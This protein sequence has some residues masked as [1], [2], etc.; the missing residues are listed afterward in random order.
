VRD[1]LEA[2]GL[3]AAALPF[4]WARP[5]GLA[6]EGEAIALRAEAL[7]GPGGRAAV[8]WCAG[9][10]GFSAT[11]EEARAE[12]AA[13]AEVL[14][15]ARRL[16]A[17][18]AGPVDFHVVSSAGGLYEGRTGVL[19]GDPPEPRRPYGRLKVEEEERAR[20]EPAVRAFVHRVASVYGPLR[21]GRRRGLL[22]TLVA[23]T[24]EDR[25]TP[26]YGD[27]ATRR[28][29][30]HAGDVAAFLARRIL[31]P[32][33]DPRPRTALLASGQATSV[34]EALAVVARVLGR[35]PRV[36]V[37]TGGDNRSPITFSPGALPSGFAPRGV[38]EGVR[39]VRD[40]ALRTGGTPR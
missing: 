14:A 12:A 6:A 5:E 30:V 28:D 38:E 34:G 24:L 9:A 23:N 17:G 26:I 2:A 31:E 4:T 15:V 25:A 35:E 7:R 19:P 21:P 16:G 32:G 29:Y 1:S 37:R 18:A 13:F 40:D 20:A 27:L 11:E 33:E 22:C 8:A 10:C 36:E 3:R 39:D